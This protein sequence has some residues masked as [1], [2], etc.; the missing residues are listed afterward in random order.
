MN[1]SHMTNDSPEDGG[2][3]LCVLR[4]WALCPVAALGQTQ[5]QVVSRRVSEAREVLREKW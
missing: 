5:G 1:T 3:G 4:L 2:L